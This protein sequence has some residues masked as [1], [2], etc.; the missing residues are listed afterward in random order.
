MLFSP[1]TKQCSR[2]SQLSE[3]MYQV[4]LT[5]FDVI[6]IEFHAQPK[7]CPHG[8]I[9][10]CCRCTG[11]VSGKEH[12]SSWAY[13]INSGPSCGNRAENHYGKSRLVQQQISITFDAFKQ[14]KCTLSFLILH[15]YHR[16]VTSASHAS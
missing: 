10:C 7:I 5:G 13:V 2:Q 16:L 8:H 6:G 4:M 11:C 12:K 9:G 1:D 15:S 14:I 3:S